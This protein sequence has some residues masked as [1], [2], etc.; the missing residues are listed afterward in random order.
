MKARS[1]NND[2]QRDSPCTLTT[3][4]ARLHGALHRHP[5]ASEAEVEAIAAVVLAIVG[6]VTVELAVV[7]AELAARVEALEA[8]V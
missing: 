6:E 5:K 2:L 8:N 4:R 3:S 7:I 1:E